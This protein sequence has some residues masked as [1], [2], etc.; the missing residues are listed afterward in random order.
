VA[1]PQESVN[2]GDRLRDIPVEAIQPN[3]DQPRK[4]FDEDALTSL[5][6]SIRERGVLQPI[7]VR[8]RTLGRVEIVA[9]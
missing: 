2:A 4:Q 6:E 9:G 7:I 3:P 8:P 1:Q 5:V